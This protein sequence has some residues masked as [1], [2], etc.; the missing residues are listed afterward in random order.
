MSDIK[1]KVVEFTLH[2][3]PDPEVQFLSVAK[4]VGKEWQCVVKTTDMQDVRYGIYIPIDAELSTTHPMF[5]FLDKKGNK[6]P[7]RIKTIRLR[8]QLSQGLLIPAPKEATLDEDWTERLGVT[9]WEPV[10][11]KHLAGDMI[12][13]PG[14]FQKYTS[15]ENWKNFPN[16]FSD[17]DMV[18]VTEKLHGCLKND[19]LISMSDGSKKKITQIN[20]GDE[21][22]GIDKNDNLTTTKVTNVFNNGK[23]KDGWLSIKIA[24]KKIGSGTAYSS[25]ICTPNHQFWSNMHQTYVDAKNL[26]VGDEVLSHR[27]KIQH[28]PVQEQI[29]LGKLLGDAS[30]RTIAS[31][32]HLEW[33]HTKE[34]EQYFDFVANGLGDLFAKK[35]KKEYMSGFGSKMIRGRTISLFSL[36]KKFSS[37]YKKGK[38]I[39]PNWVAKELTP[40]SIAFWYMDDGSLGHHEDQEDRAHFAV[41]DFSEKDCKVL[42]KGLKKFNINGVYYQSSNHD[43]NKKHS[44]IRLNAD[45]AEKLFI[46]IAPYITS[47]MQY[48]LPERH[49]VHNGNLPL[50][51]NLQYKK[52]LVPQKI[53]EIKSVKAQSLR[54]DIETETHNYFA[55]GILL[56]N[57]NARFGFV[58]E[59]KVGG[60]TYFVGTHRTA[61]SKDG[62]NLYSEISRN[63][64]VEEKLHPLLDEF[65]PKQ[66]LLVF[67]EIYGSGVQDLI[68]D[69]NKNQ[70]QF[71]VFDVLIDHVYQSWSLIER[72]ATLLGVQTV[73]LMYCGPFN[74]EETLKMRDG[75]TTLGGQHVREGVVVTSE[76][77]TYHPEVG[78]KMIKFISDD[79][80]L[81]KNS[82]DG[83]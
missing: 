74:L 39:A 15:I 68:Y 66:H 23:A 50:T 71:R 53:C 4:I 51:E 59:G 21:V 43:K 28:T 19:S 40:L 52:F 31:S 60:L 6:K 30:L 2:P 44:R 42:L 54:Y 16:V 14:N 56:H 24:K 70:Q 10:V 1:A 37:F 17:G 27:M 9:R 48:K 63:L 64:Q 81:R 77:E 29:I 3:H 33:G 35:S 80:L 79:Y 62:N 82:L 67:G 58:D 20:V 41:C 73:P 25:I 83:H 78:R 11:P 49:R 61:R 13:E 57:S 22:F 69:C 12:R 5:A 8:Q 76:P 75:K 46:L 47:C 32:A 45:E 72:V 34:H 26:S 7:F 55:H 18:R 65:N 38:K 36:K